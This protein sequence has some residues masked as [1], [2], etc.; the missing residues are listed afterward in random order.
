M[1]PEPYEN[2][3]IFGLESTGERIKLDIS[4][5]SFRLN[6]GQNILDPNQ[7]LIIVKERLRR[8]YIW[9]G[10]NSHVRKKF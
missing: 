2:F 10:V 1:M 4:E 5:E 3:M 6:N 8:I 9:K 7:V